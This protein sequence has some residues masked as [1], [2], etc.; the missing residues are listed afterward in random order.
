MTYREQRRGQRI[1]LSVQALGLAM[2][3]VYAIHNN[4]WVLIYIAVGWEL[5]LWVAH[6]QHCW[7]PDI[8]LDAKVPCDRSGRPL[9]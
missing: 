6:R 8:D 9:H 7:K 1:W 5:I 4:P 2:I 3:G